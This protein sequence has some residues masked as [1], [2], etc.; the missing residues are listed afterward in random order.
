[1]DSPSKQLNEPPTKHNKPDI[2]YEYTNIHSL[3]ENLKDLT[4]EE[5]LKKLKLKEIEIDVQYCFISTS[6]IFKKQSIKQ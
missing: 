4:F 2:I 5:K 6:K 1:M 3:F